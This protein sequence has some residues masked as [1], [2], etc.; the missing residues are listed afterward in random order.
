MSTKQK[1]IPQFD[2]GKFI[3][4]KFN[5]GHQLF[6]D[7]AHKKKK[8]LLHQ[9]NIPFEE[10]DMPNIVVVSLGERKLSLHLLTS[11]EDPSEKMIRTKVKGS[12][13]WE[14]CDL[15]F[16]ISRYTCSTSGIGTDVITW[17]KTNRVE[18]QNYNSELLLVVAMSNKKLYLAK[19]VTGKD[20][21]LVRYTPDGKVYNYSKAKLLDE[22]LVINTAGKKKKFAT[23]I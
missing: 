1:V 5:D 19:E 10:T 14:D 22:I 18:Y 8:E 4:Q 11:K 12:D 7:E 6:Q 21:V 9:R 20:L 13:V 17:L 15:L 3:Q 2:F 23:A 16:F